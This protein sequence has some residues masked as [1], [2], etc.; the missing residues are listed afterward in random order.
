M[1]SLSIR[2]VIMC[3]PRKQFMAKLSLF[4]FQQLL[5]ELCVYKFFANILITENVYIFVCIN[6][7]EFLKFDNLA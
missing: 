2:R 1:T 4:P 7:R 3:M 5:N 6:V